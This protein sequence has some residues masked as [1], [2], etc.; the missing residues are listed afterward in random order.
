MIS[1]L[2]IVVTSSS[3]DA[4]EDEEALEDADLCRG[5]PDAARVVHQ[6]PHLLGEPRQVVVELLHLP[7]AH[8][9]DGVRVLADLGER[10]T[11][12]C[13]LLRVELALVDL[14][15]PFR[16][17]HAALGHARESSQSD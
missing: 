3:S 9:Q 12:A 1:G 5:Q 17:R 11:A 6:L 4:L 15:A 14:L 13:A 16:C 10:D 2:T 7:R 8:P